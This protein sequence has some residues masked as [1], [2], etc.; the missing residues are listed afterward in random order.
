MSEI[1]DFTKV[2]YLRLPQIWAWTQKVKD[3]ISEAVTSLIWQC[4]I[5]ELGFKVFYTETYWKFWPGTHQ[6]VYY[7]R[8]NARPNLHMCIFRLSFLFSEMIKN[9]YDAEQ[10]A[11]A[12]KISIPYFI[13]KK[14]DRLIFMLRNRKSNTST[15]TKRK[16]NRYLG[17]GWEWEQILHAISDAYPVAY[18]RKNAWEYVYTYLRVN[19]CDWKK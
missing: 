1:C 19:N 12:Q 9:A 15:L 13:K 10:D 3:D 11:W 18:I 17:G 8:N 6:N 4:T 14:G 7:P 2:D 16:D 5:N